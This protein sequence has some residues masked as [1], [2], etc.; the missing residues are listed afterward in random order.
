MKAVHLVIAAMCGVFAV[1]A[2][3]PMGA[4]FCAF[5]AAG[6]FYAGVRG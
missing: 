4:A 2:E 3:S 1:T 6:N 5:M